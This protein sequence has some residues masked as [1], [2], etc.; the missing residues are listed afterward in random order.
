MR[1][2][3]EKRK[4]KAKVKAPGAGTGT[5]RERGGKEKGGNK[6]GGTSVRGPGAGGTGRSGKT[7]SSSTAAVVSPPANAL[8]RA[9]PNLTNL[10]ISILIMQ[11]IQRLVGDAGSCI[12]VVDSDDRDEQR[13]GPAMKKRRRQ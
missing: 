9:F 3:K 1:V 2:L 6:A 10:M 12:V 11:S 4:A 13:E 5:G 8:Q 7:P